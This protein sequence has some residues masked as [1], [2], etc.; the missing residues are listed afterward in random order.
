MVNSCI[1][2][3]SDFYLPFFDKVCDDLRIT[4]KFHRKVWE[5][6]MVTQA[7]DEHG[8]LDKKGLG[9]AVGQ[10]ILPA[11]YASRGADITA[12]E[13]DATNIEGWGNDKKF[14]S[15]QKAL[16]PQN[17]YKMTYRSVDMNA[18]PSNLTGFDFTWSCCSFEHCGSI[19]SGLKFVHEQMKCLKPGGWAVHTSE[20][21]LT[22]ENT[23][24]N[25]N[26]VLFRKSDVKKL[27]E[28]FGIDF[29]WTLGDTPEDNVI[30]TFP[31]KN[32][33][34]LKISLGGFTTTSFILVIQKP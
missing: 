18:I 26:T 21:N 31:F 27:C 19:E 14:T 33:P 7:L 24:D 16:D 29:D 17:L 20:L 25:A 12:T 28:E 2:K 4:N 5:Y 9:F 10:E 23:I 3:A 13:L 22:G 1:C 11:Y 6:A 32:I 30:D 8:L 15:L 34:H